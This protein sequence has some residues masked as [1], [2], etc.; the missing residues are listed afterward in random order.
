MP[1]DLSSW[2]HTWT[3][4]W[5]SSGA[6][7]L[8]DHDSSH[9]S[10]SGAGWPLAPLSSCLRPLAVRDP[11][12]DLK[13]LKKGMAGYGSQAAGATVCIRCRRG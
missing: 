8:R 12:L 11:S 6:T 9:R 4:S 3:S 5:I 1:L 13:M 10:L 2:V 7:S